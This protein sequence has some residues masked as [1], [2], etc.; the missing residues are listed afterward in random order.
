MLNRFMTNAVESLSGQL[1][2]AKVTA[3]SQIYIKLNGNPVADVVM[4]KLIEACVD[5]HAYL[6]DMFTLRLDDSDLSLLDEGTFDLAD[7]VEITGETAD[8]QKAS[9]IVGEI[10]ALEP[11]FEE[12]MTAVLV[13]RGYDKSHRLY[14]ETKS[15]AFIN[16]KDS[17]IARKIAQ[18][19]Q[20]TTEIEETHTV[21]EHIY[22]NNLSDLAFLRQRAWRI[23][24]ECFVTGDKLY[25]RQPKVNGEGITL[26]WGQDLLTFYPHLTL[27]EQVSEVQ[28]R[29]WDVAKQAAIVGQAKNGRLY[30]QR[31]E[32]QNGAQ[33]ADGFGAGK[34]VIVD[35]LVV[36]Q[37]EA[38]SLAQARLDEICG[39]FIMADG[40]AFRRPDIKA[41]DSITLAGLGKQFSGVYLVTSVSHIYTNEGLKSLF[42]LQGSRL[43]LLSEQLSHQ[44]EGKRWP[45]VV[46]AIVTNSDDPQNW[47]RVKVK[48]P[49]MSEETESDWARVM[50]LGAAPEAGLLAL[51]EVGHEVLVAFEQ[52]DFSRPYV[53]GGVWNGQHKLP[54]ETA[55]AKQG[56]R[57]LVRTWR[58]HKGH[59]VTLHDTADDRIEIVTKDGRQITLDDAQSVIKITSENGLTLTLDDNN[60]T[61]T[62][63]STQDIQIKA[64]KNLKIEANGTMDL[65][66]NGQVNIKGSLINLN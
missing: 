9:L 38:N 21:Y 44:A 14:R 3:A 63:E 27:A 40:Q 39:A 50:G 18:S 22:Q 32:A 25:F 58:S 53:L 42:Q 55:N 60:Q 36:S 62:L 19:G 45:G 61:I 12:G 49:W 43:G 57:P 65:Q 8:G 2:T 41:G 11:Q 20:L 5:Q 17:D 4:G 28:V 24:Y 34:L 7:T 23:G 33:L 13:V 1:T 47:G 10:T 29:G 16:H 35:Q 26:T 37:A 15:R 59:R 48:F 54:P 56:E 51:P 6:P 52:G 66:A 46:T 64:G 31:Q 30:P